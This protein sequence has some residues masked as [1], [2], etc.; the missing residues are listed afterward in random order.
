M[1][2]DDLGRDGYQPPR[3][4]DLIVRADYRGVSRAIV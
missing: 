3:R 2:N 1:I 4:I